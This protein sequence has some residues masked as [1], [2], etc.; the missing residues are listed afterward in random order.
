MARTTDEILQVIIDRVNATPSL[1]PI[2]AQMS[3]VSLWRLFAYCVAYCIQTMENLF[4]THRD[5]INA[6]LDTK[7]PHKLTWYKEKALAFQ[8]GFALVGDTDVYDNTG[9][10]EDEISNSQIIKNVAVSEVANLNSNVRLLI[11][12]AG[13]T[14]EDLTPIDNTQYEAFKSYISNIKDAGV[15]VT[16]INYLPDLLKPV[17]DIYYDPLLIDS[18]GNSIRNGGK[19][20]E[21]TIKSFLKELPFNGEISLMALCDKLQTIPG[22]KIPD[23]KQLLWSQIDPLSEGYGDYLNISVRQIPF[24]GYFKVEDF[25][26]INYLPYV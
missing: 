15:Y 12:I 1:A 10:T 14:G 20:I 13:Q 11:K 16:I 6:A 5:E 8:L 24:S 23:V 25:T 9:A 19:P 2:A 3:K 17:I 7:R 22:V 4:D 18:E 26:A 21:D